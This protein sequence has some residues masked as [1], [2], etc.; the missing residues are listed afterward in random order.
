MAFETIRYDVDGHVATITLDRPDVANAQDTR[1]IDELDAAFDLAD[2]DDEV[3]VVILAGSGKHFS[4]GHDL[5]ALVGDTEPDAWRLMRETP[6]G[7]FRHEKVMYFDR[8]LRIRDFRKPTIAAVQGRCIA[9]GVMLACMC[10]LIVAADDA[11]FQNPVLRM[12]GA[13]VEILVEPWEMPARKAKEFLLTAETL[14]AAEAERLGMVNRVVPAAA[15]MASARELA[16]RIALVP[17]T[18]A[19]VV[20]RSINKTLELQGQKD[21]WDYH[22]MAHHW[23]HNTATALEALAARKQKRSMGEVFS[24]HRDP[25]T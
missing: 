10:D 24:E 17:P 18:T 6:E 23:M 8:C 11:S 15:L 14:T 21:A 12:T 2:A 16:E 20:K 7:K 25:G 1:L 13:A 19:Q 5:K 4:S 9:A 3:R 22:F